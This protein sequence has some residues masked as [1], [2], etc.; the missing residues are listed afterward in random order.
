MNTRINQS[1]L[2]FYPSERTDDTAEG[3]GLALG[4]PIKGEANEIFNPISTLSRTNGD[5]SARLVYAG[6]QRPDDEPLI[7]SFVAITKPPADPATSYLLFEAGFGELRRDGIKRVENYNTATIESAMTLLS[8]PA[9]GS[10]VVQAYQRVG[11]ALP[12]VGDV[13]CLRQDK[14]GYTDLIQYIRITKV[15]ATERIFTDDNGEFERMVVKMEINQPIGYDFV[16]VDYPSRKYADAPT[17][18]RETHV[19]DA[20]NYFGV[21]PIVQAI[22]KGVMS[23]QVSSLF[24]KIIPTSQ[25]ETALADIT[26]GGERT[27]HFGKSTVSLAL[28]RYHSQ[29]TVSSIYVGNAILPGSLV[30][31]STGGNIS[32]RGK[33]LYQGDKAIGTVDYEAGLL[34]I[35]EPTWT[36]NLDRLSFA[37]ASADRQISDTAKIDVTINNRSYNYAMTLDPIPAKGSLVASYRSGGRFYTLTDDGSGKLVGASVSHG[38]GVLSYATGTVTLS[39]GAMP[40]VGSSILLSWATVAPYFDR[41]KSVPK[42]NYVLIPN[43]EADPATLVLSYE[44]NGAKRATGGADGKITG[45]LTGVYKD[46]RIVLDTPLDPTKTVSVTYNTGDKKHQQHKAPLRDGFGKITL[47]LGDVPIVPN[48]VRLRWNLLIE[49]YQLI[50]EGDT[51][52]RL[53]DPYKTVRDDGKGKLIDETG[54]EVGTINYTERKLTFNPDTTVQ[55][56]KAKYVQVKIGEKILSTEGNKQ[57]FKP[58]L[59]NTFVGYEYVPAGASM[60]IDES[61]MAEVWYFDTSSQSQST[62]ELVARRVIDILPHYSE[63]VSPSSLSFVIGDRRYFDKG[64]QMHYA[65]DTATGQSINAGVIDYQQGVITLTDYTTDKLTL[66][67]VITSIDGNPVDG[68]VFATPTAP[69]RPSSLQ[70]RATATDGTKITAIANA[71]GEIKGDWIEGVVDVEYGVVSV[72]FGKWHT[73]TDDIKFKDWYNEGNVENGQVWQSLPVF[74]HSVIYN[75]VSYRYLPINGTHIQIDTVRLPTDGQIPIFRRGDTVLIGNR[76]TQS[77]GSAHTA[78]ATVQ[79]DRTKLDR[80][81]VMDN[82]GKAVNAE[83]W[84]YDL[85]AGTITW[86]T[87]L[88]LSGYE[89]PLKVMHAKEEKNR[90]IETDIDGTLSLMFPTKHDYDVA[91]TYVSSVLIGGDLEVRHSVPFVQRNWDNEWRNERMG[92]P[93]LNKLNLKDYPM[94]LTDDGAISERWA[95]VFT[96]STQFELYGETLGFVSKTDTLQDLAP[97]NPATGKPYFKIPKQAFGGDAPWATRNLIRFNTTGTLLPVWVLRAVQPTN[98][99]QDD[100]DGFTLCLFG[101][102]TEI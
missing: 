52:T 77:I 39:L 53:V 98:T 17:K 56:P 1:D 94:V 55:I 76:Q 7:G 79:L 6:V 86:T 2:K 26:A 49:D 3:G 34:L 82:T 72:K 36:G 100:E 5:F 11:E 102:T 84:T 15:E 37:P 20:A 87:P 88:D 31:T 54:V 85:D 60:P 70:I 47:D 89:L 67:S 32:D 74:A 25:I 13:Y 8:N 90:I 21:K 51:Q 46:G 41:S 99:T 93:I 24:D 10:K 14:K 73:V 91:D 59:K 30:I 50:T 22:K 44:D 38:T 35:N 33:T 69:L 12:Q 61:A 95:I 64:G 97:I 27:T 81:C 101:D 68:V 57:T 4:T 48:S 40:D 78:G 43:K 9:R 80:I 23:V 92:E 29:N 63:T 45:D 83:L 66:Q 58:I 71:K 28:N 65:L 96:S 19:A 62:D 16:G 42:D 75:A 18:I